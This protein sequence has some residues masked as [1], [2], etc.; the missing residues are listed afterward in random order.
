M[1]RSVLFKKYSSHD[2]MI[3][4]VFEGRKA[5]FNILLGIF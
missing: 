1:F 2:V 5:E 4:H 3:G